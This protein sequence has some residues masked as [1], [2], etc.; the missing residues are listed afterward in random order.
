MEVDEEIK[1]PEDVHE[2]FGQFFDFLNIFSITPTANINIFGFNLFLCD[3]K[4]LAGGCEDEDKF[5]LWKLSL[6]PSSVSL[7]SGLKPIS[8]RI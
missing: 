6:S 4:I 1:D 3:P 8:L 2:E 5:L 7:F